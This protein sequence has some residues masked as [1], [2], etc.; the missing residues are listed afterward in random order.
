[1]LGTVEKLQSGL[2]I[3]PCMFYL[4]KLELQFKNLSK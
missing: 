1:M 2:A 3:T 4:P